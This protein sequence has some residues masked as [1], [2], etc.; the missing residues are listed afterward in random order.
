MHATTLNRATTPNRD[1]AAAI[2][3]ARV[4]AALENVKFDMNQNVVYPHCNPISHSGGVARPMGSL[5]LEGAIASVAGMTELPFKDPT[6]RFRRDGTIVTA[7]SDSTDCGTSLTALSMRA[8][9]RNLPAAP[10][11][12]GSARTDADQLSFAV[13]GVAAHADGKA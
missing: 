2:A 4:T 6:R 1:T 12:C 7:A 9:G 13:T 3:C 8:T 10:H 5:T 11:H